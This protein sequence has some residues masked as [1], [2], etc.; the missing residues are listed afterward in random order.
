MWTKHRARF[1]VPAAICLG[2]AGCAN[3]QPLDYPGLA[4]APELAA[5]PR[6]RSGRVPFLYTAYH[7]DWGRYT[8]CILDPVTV[9]S[10][11]DGQFGNTSDADK[12]ALAK[13]MQDQFSKALSTR[14][15][16]TARPGPNT[17]RIHLTLTGVETNTPVLSTLS[18]V[19]P[20]GVLLNGVQTVRGKEGMFEGSVTFAVEIYDS[21]SNRL[22]RAYVSKQYPF[23]E[24]VA[25]S[26][27]TLDAS[28]AG[29]RR[30][31][32]AL[33]AELQ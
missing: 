21:A 14:C 7:V 2:A 8:G 10:G 11:P 4:S 12:A 27:G 18:Q 13:Y 33:L 30:G 26:F 9:Y 3:T 17:L 32:E 15:M 29:I 24:N 16:L 22:L 31:A 19:A 20:A 28:R 6:D 5:N 1:L 23:A 25:Y